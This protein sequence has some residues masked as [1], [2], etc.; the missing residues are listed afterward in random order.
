MRLGLATL[1]LVLASR[2]ALASPADVFG[3]GSEAAALGGA[4][5]A[6]ATGWEASYYNPAGLVF[7][8]RSDRGAATLGV[9]G[10]GS[11]LAINGKPY[12]VSEQL[13]V[14]LGAHLPLPFGSFLKDRLAVGFSMYALPKNVLRVI[15]RLPSEEF[16]PYYDNRT[17]RLVILPALGI[18]LHDRVAIGVG[19]NFLAGLTGSVASGQG[20]TRAIDARV[21]EEVYTNVKLNTGLRVEV[22]WGV[23][24]GAAYRPAFSV[25]FRTTTHNVVAGQNI[26]L[27]V[28]AEGLFSPHQVALGAAWRWRMLA[29]SFDADWSK[30]SSWKGPYVAVSSELPLAGRLDVAV[31]HLRFSDVWAL[32]GGAEV[33]VLETTDVALDA[34]LGGGFEPSPIPPQHGVTNLVDGDK[35]MLSAGAGVRVSHLLPKPVRFDVHFQLQML[36]DRADA[37]IRAAAGETPDPADKLRDEVKDLQG[38]LSTMGFQTSNP[39]YPVLRGGGVVYA[40]GFNVTFEL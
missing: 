27:D 1:L 19:F 3:L 33:R 16:Y 5:T 29:L 24:L 34:R 40:G 26:D 35:L 4:V 6:R 22:G 2:A 7:E 9:V 30:W 8:S 12:A 10:S 13:G 18:K 28:D 36:G 14:Q 17:Q 39:G 38:D 25:P 21:D 23:S 37:K 20:E 15:A 31:P 32:R 11:T